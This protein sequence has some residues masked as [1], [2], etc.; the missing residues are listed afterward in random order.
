MGVYDRDYYKSNYQASYGTPWV[1]VCK[2][3]VGINV[4]L[5][6]LQIITRNTGTDFGESGFITEWLVLDPKKVMQGEVWRL[7]SYGFLH[8]MA[9][10]F[11]LLMNMFVLWMFGKE[12]E[13]VL[14]GKEFLL[15]YLTSIFIGGIIFVLGYL[16]GLH[17]AFAVCLGASGG[18]SAVIILFACWFPNRT[19]L[20]FFIIPMPVWIMAVLFVALDALNLISGKQGS[21]AVEVH[22][23][24]SLF[25][26]LYHY[27]RWKL[28]PEKIPSLKLFRKKPNLRLYQEEVSVPR[29][30]P[31]ELA[32]S[33][34]MVT[35]VDQ[36]LE[37]ISLK[38]SSS[39]TAEEKSFLYKAS[40]LI[41]RK[42]N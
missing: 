28:L 11:H 37:K 41:K 2:W 38:G 12:V 5:F 24:G 23:S 25:A 27:F 39:L 6:I 17:Q 14:G 1:N 34:E 40:E 26:L 35:R 32:L 42:R 4:L 8:S 19:I 30:E 20:L 29:Y 9:N 15:F 13:D 22:L 21:V 16:S 33:E 3:L 36:I 10:P 31:K 7:L 18:V